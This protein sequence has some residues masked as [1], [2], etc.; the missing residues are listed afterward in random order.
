MARRTFG[1]ARRLPSGRWQARYS[2]KDGE[3]ITA[4]ITFPTKAAAQR[5][6]ATVEADMARGTWHDPTL[7]HTTIAEWADRWLA[8]KLPTVR[9]ATADQYEYIL[10]LHIVPHLGDRELGTFTPAD[11]Q[12]WLGMMHR[13]SGLAPNTVAKVYRLLKNM[14]G[15]AVEVGMIAR[16]PCTIRGAGTERPPEIEV[17]TP[18]QVAALADACG[19]HYGALVF[20]A[21]Y[22]GLRW[23]ELGGLQR[24]HVDLG[25]GVV[26]RRAEAQRGQRRPRDRC[27]EDGRW[28]AQRCSAGA[29]RAGA[30]APPAHQRRTARTEPR[31]HRRR[32]RLPPAQQLPPAGL[33]PRHRVSRR[34]RLTVPRPSTHRGDARCV[35]R[36]T[37]S[38]ADVA[39]GSCD[40]SRRAPVSASRRRPGC[41]DRQLDRRHG[42]FEQRSASSAVALRFWPSLTTA[43]GRLIHPAP[44]LVDRYT[45][46]DGLGFHEKLVCCSEGVAIGPRQ[47][48]DEP[49][50]KVGHHLT[51]AFDD[52]QERQLG[53]SLL[54]EVITCRTLPTVPLQE[55]GD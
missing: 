18:E 19:D 38:G 8:T 31:L 10:R 2:T 39:D 34:A 5:W 22:G 6:L 32:G 40:A 16:N 48:L 25:T 28:P 42:A 45:K 21:A 52:G 46:P 49:R 26:A 12:A 47:L 11:V 43:F 33:G 17:A 41:R 13:R 9:R 54:F 20:V 1:S 50:V 44:G 3:R 51:M 14:L 15:G 23:G 53:P 30:R 37:A 27:P 36:R 29:R 7:G 55:L 24:R 4:P 35:D